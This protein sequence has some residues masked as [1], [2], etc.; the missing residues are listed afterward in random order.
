MAM[1][2]L[3]WLYISL[4]PGSMEGDPGSKRSHELLGTVEA[5]IDTSERPFVK[6][7]TLPQVKE[8]GRDC[9]STPLFLTSVATNG[10]AGLLS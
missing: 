10:Q 6:K 2:L 7:A 3:K 4:M 8:R 1:V 5:V 9:I